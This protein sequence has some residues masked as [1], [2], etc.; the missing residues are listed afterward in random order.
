MNIEDIRPNL[1]LENLS[2]GEVVK[3]LYVAPAGTDAVRVARGLRMRG[4]A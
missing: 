2:V 4:D 1:Y 3:G